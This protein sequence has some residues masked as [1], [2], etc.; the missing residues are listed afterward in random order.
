MGKSLA[1]E[2][3]CVWMS[4]FAMIGMNEEIVKMLNLVMAKGFVDVMRA[5]V[6]TSRAFA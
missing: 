3:R 6:C 2:M 1:L 4:G 5:R